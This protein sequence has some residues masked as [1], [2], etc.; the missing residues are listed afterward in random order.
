MDT[1]TG[2]TPI[3]WQFALNIGRPGGPTR[4]ERKRATQ[5]RRRAVARML[6][7]GKSLPEIARAIGRTE[8]TVRQHVAALRRAAQRRA[9]A[10]WGTPAADTADLVEALEHALQKIRTALEDADAARP[11]Y[12]GLLDLEVR[13][14]RD[15]MAIRRD[16][17]ERR[18][19]LGPTEPDGPEAYTNEELLEQARELGIDT[20]PYEAA[21]RP[22]RMK[23]PA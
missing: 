11:G 1:K 23:E 14:L 2:A 12:R 3:R 21:L 10:E 7:A 20:A 22:K 13:T 18:A 15:L 9:V 6:A 16:L 8:R 5:R 17:A 19:R 4:R